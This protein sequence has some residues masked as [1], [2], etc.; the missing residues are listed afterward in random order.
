MLE[1]ELKK[2]IVLKHVDDEKNHKHTLFLSN[3]K[4]FQLSFSSRISTKEITYAKLPFDK[5]RIQVIN[6][7][8]MK[9]F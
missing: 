1:W 7:I 3:F 2:K 8:S 6:I 9:K 5:I 4:R